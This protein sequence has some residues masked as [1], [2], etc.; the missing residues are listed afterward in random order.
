MA[1]IVLSE[2][3]LAVDLEGFVELFWSK[4]QWYEEFL[5]EKL[6]D[7]SVNVGEWS[8]NPEDPATQVRTVKSYHPSKISFPG[9]PSH[10]EVCCRTTAPIYTDRLV[11]AYYLL[12]VKS[13]KAQTLSL[14]KDAG[15]KLQKVTVRE[16]NSFRGIPYADY[17]NVITEW[18]VVPSA[19]ANSGA[20]QQL[21]SSSG[22][23]GSC[24]A[25]VYLDFQFHKS[26]WLQGTIESNTKA[27]LIGVYEL[28]L[29]SAQRTI[30]RQLDS[31]INLRVHVPD[32]KDLESGQGPTGG[33]GLS[34]AE[35]DG[36]L[37]MQVVRIDS[38]T[39]GAST[40]SEG[41]KLHCVVT[42]LCACRHSLRVPHLLCTG[43]KLRSGSGSDYR[44][45]EDELEFYDCEDLEGAQGLTRSG[46]SRES[47]GNVTSATL[48][49]ELQRY[50]PSTAGAGAGAFI[51]VGDGRAQGFPVPGS[52]ELDGTTSARDIAVTIVE[53]VFVMAEFTYWQVR[54]AFLPTTHLVQL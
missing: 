25:T 46:R 24:K 44:S 54:P 32:G 17:F 7:L 1:P 42:V 13:W 53:A 20:G 6:L 41:S 52:H 28:W 50:Y 4:P 23:S 43:N 49:A 37:D 35:G 47:F 3:A 34:P 11:K 21:N 19:P 5:T 38:T 10:A 30:R 27:E 29:Q 33:G 18:N 12:S 26:T 40:P 31:A 15:G 16:T 2:F 9:L 22:A 51:G 39:S 14:A 8:P 36:L 45:E 48:S